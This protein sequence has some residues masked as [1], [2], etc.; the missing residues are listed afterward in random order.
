MRVKCFMAGLVAGLVAVW[1]LGCANPGPEPVIPPGPTDPP[2]TNRPPHIIDTTSGD[3]ADL[4][5]F[6][7]G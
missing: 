5:G 4:K 3:W 1:F 2:A 7:S 6:C